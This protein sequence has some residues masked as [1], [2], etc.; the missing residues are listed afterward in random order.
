MNV[1]QTE[2]WYRRK[3][4][5]YMVEHYEEL[6]DNDEIEWWSDPAPNVWLFDIPEQKVRVELTCDHK[7]HVTE[8]RYDLRGRD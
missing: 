2:R 7:G 1:K 3:L 5:N 4:H 6:E 8:Q